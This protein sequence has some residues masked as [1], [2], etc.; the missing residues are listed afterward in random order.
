M[1]G[2]DSVKE[3][4][5]NELNRRLRNRDTISVYELDSVINEVVKE[6]TDDI[7]LTDL[8]GFSLQWHPLVLDIPNACKPN[9]RYQPLELIRMNVIDDLINEL[10]IQLKWSGWSDEHVNEEI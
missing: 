4:A 7:C 8:L 6:I 10:I 2:Y 5:V 3:K 1:K 9:K